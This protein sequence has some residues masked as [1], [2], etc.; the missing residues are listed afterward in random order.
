MNEPLNPYIDHTLLRTEATESEVRRT[1]DEAAEHRFAAA[2]IPPVYVPIAAERLA[3]S[4]VAVGT[5]VGFPMG[6]VEP[7]VRIEEG[8]RAIAA[9]ARE[10]DTVLNLSWLL[11]G[12]VHR[13]YDDLA[14]WVEAMRSEGPP[15]VLKVIVEA[16]LLSEADKRRAA[17]IVAQAGADF[18]KTSTGFFGSGATLADVELLVRTVGDRV[19][20]KAAGGIRTPAFARALIAAGARRLGT[21][22]G[23]ALVAPEG[24][25]QRSVGTG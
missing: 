13:A 25:A 14:G 18:V 19:G 3:G 22:A 20:V 8:R 10:L 4:G 2:V 11:S 6:Y 21:S 24:E 15:V 23:V 17:E 16:G 12:R 7:R 5:V 9:G 1:L